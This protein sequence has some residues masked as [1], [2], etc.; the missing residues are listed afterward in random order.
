VPHGVHTT[1]NAVQAVGAHTA[2]STTL[3]DPGTFELR[4]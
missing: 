1:M 4:E 3:V 2:H